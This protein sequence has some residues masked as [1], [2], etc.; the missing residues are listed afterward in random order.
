MRSVKP[1]EMAR[2]CKRQRNERLGGWIH[3]PIHAVPPANARSDQQQ[4]AGGAG[5]K[6]HWGFRGFSI[7]LFYTVLIFE[8]KMANRSKCQ[9]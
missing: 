5:L 4:K 3:A 2:L 1:S 7:L 6:F 8:Q 9:K